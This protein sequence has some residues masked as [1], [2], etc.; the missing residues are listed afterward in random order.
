M[1]LIVPRRQ[2]SGR[3]HTHRIYLDLQIDRGA[4]VGRTFDDHQNLHL[5]IV[6][7]HEAPLLRVED[8]DVH[9]PG[10]DGQAEGIARYAAE[11]GPRLG[12]GGNGEQ[13]RGQDRRGLAISSHDRHDNGL[14]PVF[15]RTLVRGE[16]DR[17]P[18][19][20][21]PAVLIRH[22]GGQQGDVRSVGHEYVRVRIQ[23]DEGLKDASRGGLGARPSRTGERI[24]I[25]G[26]QF[27]PPADVEHA[28]VVRA[29]PLAKRRTHL[30]RKGPGVRP[31]L[32]IDRRLDLPRTGIDRLQRDGLHPF[33]IEVQVYVLQHEGDPLAGEDRGSRREGPV[34]AQ[35][36]GERLLIIRYG[37]SLLRPGRGH[38]QKN[39]L[40]PEVR[41]YPDRDLHHPG[42]VHVEAV[43]R[44]RHHAVLFL[45]PHRGGDERDV[46]RKI[47]GEHDLRG[48]RLPHIAQDDGVGIGVALH[49]RILGGRHREPERRNRHIDGSTYLGGVAHR[50]VQA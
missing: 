31:G 50:L 3:E 20:K 4:V 17:R 37:L 45:P 48:Q 33:R 16:H 42:L 26:D 36:K 35:G 1:H 41:R 24:L 32:G 12:D 8:P 47:L 22:P 18:V 25:C 15:E 7:A 29:C 34:V 19:R 14:F 11:D 10:E 2:I 38:G 46:F 30:S 21:R 49:H 6:R 40:A 23:G 43:Q 9:G 27:I 28:V 39:G 13:R 5:G 44:E